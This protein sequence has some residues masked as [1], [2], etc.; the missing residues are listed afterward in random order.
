MKTIIWDFNG[1]IVDDVQGCLDI[2]NDMLKKR[3]MKGNYTLEHY[4]NLFCFPVIDYYK[5]IGYTFEKETYEDVSIEF[6][7]AYNALFPYFELVPGVKRLLNES[8]EKGYQNLIISATRQSTLEFEVQMLGI[9]RFFDT[10]IGIDDDLAFSKVEHAKRFMKESQLNPEDCLYI[11]DSLHD[12]ECAQALHIENVI[13][14]ACGHQ[15]FEV[16]KNHWHNVIHTMD[17]VKL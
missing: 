4:R 15:S 9:S 12:L 1:T 2:E 10:L 8:L 16:L 14:V 11:G 7:D 3:G 13:L 5:K 6:N 17:E